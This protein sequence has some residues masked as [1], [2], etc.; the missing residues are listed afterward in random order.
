MPNVRKVV[1]SVT[2]RIVECPRPFDTPGTRN[3]R[4]KN[5]VENL[6]YETESWTVIYKY[7]LYLQSIQ[8]NQSG[9]ANNGNLG[10][11]IQ[12]VTR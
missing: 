10:S 8:L 1:Q 5:R 3:H 11:K 12:A 4:W 9:R 6:L 2:A 7:E